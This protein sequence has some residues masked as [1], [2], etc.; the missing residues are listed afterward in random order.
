ML[1]PTDMGG[2]YYISLQAAA[3]TIASAPCL[4]GLDPSP[5]QSGRVAQSLV[6]PNYQGVP[7]ITE[8]AVSYPRA[9]AVLVFRAVEQA[10]RACPTFPI[11]VAGS[12]VRVPMELLELPQIGQQE[13]T[14][15]GQFSL[16]GR[17]LLLQVGAVLQDQTLLV[18]VYYDTVPPSDAIMGTFPSTL[19]AAVGKLS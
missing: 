3:T 4:A 16:A 18:L 14:V 15:Q 1:T 10:L 12:Q 17:T 5:L 19:G 9:R 7:N 6:G 8:L 11:D 2:F 13:I